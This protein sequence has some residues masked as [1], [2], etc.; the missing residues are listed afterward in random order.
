MNGIATSIVRIPIR[1]VRLIRLLGVRYA[2]HF[3]LAS[4]RRKAIIELRVPGIA[5]PVFCRN[6]GSDIFVLWQTFGKRESDVPLDSDP[7]VIV[8]G[9]A[10]TG[11]TTLLFANRFP[12][13]EIIAVEPDEENARLFRRNLDSYR[14]VRLVQRAIWKS[15]TPLEIKNPDDWSWAFSVTEVPSATTCSVAGITMADLVE[16]AGGRRINLLKLDIEG[17]E[18]EV[19]SAG[20][21]DWLEF[22]DTLVIEIHDCF[23]AGCSDAVNA[24]ME[25][26]GFIADVRGQYTVFSRPRAPMARTT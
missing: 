9:G 19:F 25:Q 6:S 17:A 24:A 5:T 15:R 13:A 11:F 2:M 12:Q 14:N 4:L 26:H 22:V 18:R 23:V 20:S 16:Q 1:I 10:Y 8:D 21:L 3:A 7:V